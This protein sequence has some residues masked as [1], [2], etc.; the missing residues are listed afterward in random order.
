MYIMSH[1]TVQTNTR[2]KHGVIT[3]EIM[4]YVIHTV[5]GMEEQCRQAL[6]RCLEQTDY[7]T[8]FIPQ[9]IAQKH[10]KKEWHAVEKTLL[11]GCL[12][13]ESGHVKEVRK[14]LE[15]ISQS[16]E[17]VPADS[18]TLSPITEEEQ[19]I[20]SG[21]MD[22][23]YVVKYSEGFMID[24]E[25]IVMRGPL[26]HA[27]DYVRKV[28]R[29]RRLAR[30]E[31]P[32]SGELTPMEVGFGAVARITREEF[33]T[34]VQENIQKQKSSASR[35]GDVQV[36]KGVFAGMTGTLA[37]A[38]ETQDERTVEVEME[39]F[40]TGTKIEFWRDEIETLL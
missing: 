2:Q 26:R 22:E 35:Q 20:L 24:D 8:M 39:L 3:G 23:H 10:F 19:K 1:R 13:I 17:E 33:Q 38:D 16:T 36:L 15:K 25:V 4:W 34:I 28:D 12:F 29:H 7:E 9:Y 40:G 31:V 21:I 11:P 6:E 5:S 37:D 30:I 27:A 14:C 18:K 32:L